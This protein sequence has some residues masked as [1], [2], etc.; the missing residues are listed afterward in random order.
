[1]VSNGDLGLSNSS[2]DVEELGSIRIVKRPEDTNPE[3]VRA[4]SRGEASEDVTFVILPRKLRRVRRLQGLTQLRKGNNPDSIVDKK[5]LGKLRSKYGI[6]PNV[7]IRLARLGEKANSP[8]EDWTCFY[9]CIFKYGFRFPISKFVKDILVYYDLA[10]A[11]LMLNAWRVLLGM[12]VL[13][14]MLDITF[15][16]LEFVNWYCIVETMMILVG[17]TLDLDRSSK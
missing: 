8:N 3:E 9:T 5:K 4:S 16:I 1:M 15:T 14:E 7:E 17:T 10:P 13:L 6:P 2:F 12:E 11:Q